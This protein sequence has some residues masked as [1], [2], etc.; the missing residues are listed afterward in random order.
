MTP[1]VSSRDLRIIEINRS[2]FRFT[3]LAP[4]SDY[5][6]CH[7]TTTSCINFRTEAEVTSSPVVTSSRS[8]ASSIGSETIGG[9]VG[10]A[11]LILMMCCAAVFVKKRRFSMSHE[12]SQ[13]GC[14]SGCEETNTWKYSS[15]S[16]DG[17]SDNMTPNSYFSN[18]DSY[19]NAYASGSKPTQF[20]DVTNQSTNQIVKYHY[21]PT[22][23]TPHKTHQSNRHSQIILDGMGGQQSFS[24]P[25]GGQLASQQMIIGGQQ[26]QMHGHYHQNSFNQ[27]HTSQA[28]P[29]Q[30]HFYSHSF[31]QPRNDQQEFRY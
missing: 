28:P 18:N 14:E 29:T 22:T 9:V 11:V 1:R 30:K 17:R 26:G 20:P 21:Q 16:N 3:D 13:S 15:G 7:V 31:T 6:V 10:A 2:Y 25:M 8:D 23:S 4:G 19:T 12:K 24:Q 5:K 27:F